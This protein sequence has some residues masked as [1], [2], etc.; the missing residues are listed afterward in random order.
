MFSTQ[1]SKITETALQRSVALN[2]VGAER[3]NGFALGGDQLQLAGHGRAAAE[4]ARGE[5]VA[6]TDDRRRRQRDG[7]RA[8]VDQRGRDAVKETHKV[9][10]PETK[11]PRISEAVRVFVLRVTEK[12]TPRQ[13][14]AF[15][16]VGRPAR[17][18]PADD[19][20]PAEM[21]RLAASC[22]RPAVR[23]KLG[24]LLSR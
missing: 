14:G 10:S 6:Q 22:E 3:G 1:S 8:G 2:R 18:A 21:L 13:C 23:L 9:Q 7:A 20:Q 5:G 19:G 24:V 11:K 4:N 16:W 15:I 12:K 17:A